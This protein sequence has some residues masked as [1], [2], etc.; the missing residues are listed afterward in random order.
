MRRA[1]SPAA[2]S[3]R[4]PPP[5]PSAPRRARP[6]G[7][8]PRCRT[9]RRGHGRP[10]PPRGRRAARSAKRRPKAGSKW[11]AWTR[12]SPS[13][14]T[15]RGGRSGQGAGSAAAVA[16]GHPRGRRGYRGRS[17]GTRTASWATHGPTRA[18]LVVATL[19][20]NGT[21]PAFRSATSS[22]LRS[23][24]HR[25]LVEMAGDL[26]KVRVRVRPA[27][28]GH[29][30]DGTTT[31]VT[32]LRSC[33]RVAVHR[34]A[35]TG[36]ADEAHR[37]RAR[38]TAPGVRR[39][40]CRPGTPRVA[41]RWRSAWLASRGRSCPC[42]GR[43]GHGTGRGRAHE[44]GAQCC[45]PEAVSGPGESHTDVGGVEARVQPDHEQSH[46]GSDDVG[47]GAGPD[48][49]GSHVVIVDATCPTSNP[50]PV[51]TSDSRRGVHAAKN[52]P[53]MRSAGRASP[54]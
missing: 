1:V 11:C 37:L 41:T 25:V 38:A 32:I 44:T 16:A 43:A 8:R 23:E 5:C 19:R 9:G 13:S 39:G 54:S 6:C 4:G 2:G 22:P 40:P 33:C 48:R 24:R 52:R 31:D 35:P 21:I 47:Q 29:D 42:H 26:V 20:T 36:Q 15:R 46:P 17:Q 3:G 7:R 12:R 45:R 27:R 51:S 30:V 50:A 18:T 53:P 28:R 14:A 34:V 49:H 10:A